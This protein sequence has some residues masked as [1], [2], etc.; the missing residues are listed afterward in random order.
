MLQN[1]DDLKKPYVATPL[2]T[3]HWRFLTAFLWKKNIDVEKPKRQMRTKR[4]TKEKRLGNKKQETQKNEQGMMKINLIYGCFYLIKRKQTKI[5][6]D[7]QWK[8]NEDRKP[9]KKQRID[10]RKKL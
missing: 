6:K 3:K 8:T 4:K 5:K 10:E 7:K 1:T 2:L 9:E